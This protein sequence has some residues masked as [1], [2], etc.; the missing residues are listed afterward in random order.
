M[1]ARSWKRAT[2]RNRRP[3]GAASSSRCLRIGRT[4]A[5]DETETRRPKKT[6]W[7]GAASP[8]PREREPAGG[9]QSHLERAADE[10]RP[11]ERLEAAQ[12]ELEADEEEDERDA[13]LGDRLDAARLADPPERVRPDRDAGDEE[14]DDLRKLQPAADEEDGKRRREDDREVPEKRPLPHGVS[15]GTTRAGLLFHGAPRASRSCRETC[16]AART[17]CRNRA[18]GEPNSRLNARLNAGSDS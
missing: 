3:Y 13:E 4:T 10:R 6:A 2:A 9:R 17:S 1:T 7:F 8:E 12:R 16:R 18:G 5:V 11:A 14:P 15:I